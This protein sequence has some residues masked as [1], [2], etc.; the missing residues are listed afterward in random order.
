MAARLGERARGAGRPQSGWKPLAAGSRGQSRAG[1]GGVCMMEQGLKRSVSLNGPG[2]SKDVL[3]C[4]E[5][6]LVC[7]PEM[8]GCLRRCFLAPWRFLAIAR[9]IWVLPRLLGCSVR[10]LPWC[11]G[12]CLVSPRRHLG[13]A[14]SLLDVPGRWI[15]DPES[16]LVA[17]EKCLSTIWRHLGTQEMCLCTQGGHLFDPG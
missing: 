8:P 14:G 5:E 11:T 15:C 3:V 4:A 1:Q 16:S 13:D 7:S 2:N 10:M 17:A 6:M 9:T 12:R